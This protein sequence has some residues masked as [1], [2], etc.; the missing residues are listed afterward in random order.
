MV[1]CYGMR[2]HFISDHLRDN[3]ILIWWN[4]EEGIQ[5]ISTDKSYDTFICDFNP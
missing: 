2:L 3:F 4:I 1:Q 5:K